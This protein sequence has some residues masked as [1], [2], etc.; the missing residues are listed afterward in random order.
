MS[1]A[2]KCLLAPIPCQH[3][4]ECE[5]RAHLHSGLAALNGPYWHWGISTAV[6]IENPFE[7]VEGKGQALQCY[8]VRAF[9]LNNSS[10]AVISGR[11]LSA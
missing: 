5:L 9:T 2:S 3:R 1:S 10:I 4:R 11:I 6:D 8:T 7:T